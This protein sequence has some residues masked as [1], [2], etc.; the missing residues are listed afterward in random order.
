MKEKNIDID[1]IFEINYLDSVKY[2]CLTLITFL[3]LMMYLYRFESL[4]IL[5]YSQLL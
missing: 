1:E 3:I 5:S 2:F 4:S